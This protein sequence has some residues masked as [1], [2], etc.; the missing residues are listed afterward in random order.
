MAALPGSGPLPSS[1]GAGRA[2]GLGGARP[3]LIIMRLLLVRARGC[4]DRLRGWRSG[5]LSGAEAQGSGTNVIELFCFLVWLVTSH[6]LLS[7]FL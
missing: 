5:Q 7:L 2:G 3:F 1:S 6:F 4:P